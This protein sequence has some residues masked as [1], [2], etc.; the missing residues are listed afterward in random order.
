MRIVV[1]A[2]AL[3][4]ALG[5][6]ACGKKAPIFPNCGDNSINGDETDLDCGGPLC[7]PCNAGKHCAVDK[8]CRS[9]IC[10]AGACAAPSCTDG[11]VNGSESDVD[12]GGP[13]RP[14]C[15]H[16]RARA[17]GHDR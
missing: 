4:L 17:G 9:K 5:G 10:T 1:A 15:A 3:A 7:T 14:P 12:C 16:G 2:V 6:G 13:D 11:I 8:D